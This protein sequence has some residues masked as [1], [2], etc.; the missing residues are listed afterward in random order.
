MTSQLASQA[1][2]AGAPRSVEDDAARV[3][4][5]AA[6]GGVVLAVTG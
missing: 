6:G 5:A 2:T 4:S 1:T 3:A